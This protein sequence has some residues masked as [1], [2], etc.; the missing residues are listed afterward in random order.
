VR[1]ALTGLVEAGKP[2]DLETR[3]DDW[4]AA[5]REWNP[6]SFQEKGGHRVAVPLAAGD[7]LVGVMVVADRV[8]GVPFSEEEMDLLGVVAGQVQA[9]LVNMDLSERLGQMREL[10]AFQTMSAFFVH[11]LKNTAS[12]LSLT[13]EN[14]PRHFNDPSFREDAIRAVARSVSRIEALIRKLTALR[15]KLDIRPRQASLNSLAQQT[16]AA[17]A[18]AINPRP[19]LDLGNVPDLSFDPEQMEKVLTNLLLNA[20]DAS[21]PGRE[22]SVSTRMHGG[23]AVL[24]VADS[25]CG[26]SRRFIEESLFRPFKSTKKDGMGI[27]LFQSR[28]IVEA[29]GG[30]I[31]VESEEGVGSIFRVRLPVGRA[32]S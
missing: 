31:E 28:M 12:T 4:A 7:G 22:I 15:Q 19:A 11:D 16:V 32:G 14:M 18:D 30:K 1:D 13:L 25:G 3:K 10:E 24:A 17:L 29:H 2:F 26:M 20:R 27:G 5:L 9:A 8:A 21:D 6:V 23:M